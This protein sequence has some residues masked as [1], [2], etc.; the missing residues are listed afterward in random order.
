MA[1]SGNEAGVRDLII[2]GAEIDG[3]VRSGSTPLHLAAYK[4]HTG[5]ARL[6]IEHGAKVN[7]RTRA[8][9]TP[10]DWAR[11]NG[12]EETVAFLIAHGAKTG[13]VLPPKS[14]VA[15]PAPTQRA[16]PESPR[17]VLVRRRRA[18][19]KY[20]LLG[21]PEH[22]VPEAEPEKKSAASDN[23]ALSRTSPTAPTARYRI[24]LGAFSS[25]QRAREAWS[26]Y[27]K[28]YPQVLGS[29]ELILEAV[30]VKDK[31]YHRVQVGP[32]GGS[33]ASAACTRLKQA[34]Q[35]C[36]VIQRGSS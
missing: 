33:D 34:G 19:L 2:S 31:E 29:H 4:G 23:K 35:A 18:P 11:R 26:R 32:M 16:A 30:T 10:L 20:G 7:A 6:L 28:K 3:R 15:L 24:Q 8:G 5:V 21:V 27:T 9:I 12:H 13:K 22:I 17:P 36:V 1:F 14:S 25:E